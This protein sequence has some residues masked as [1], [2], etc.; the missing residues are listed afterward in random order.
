M[1]IDDRF[2]CAS[3]P[4]DWQSIDD[5]DA[6]I[7]HL[8]SLLPQSIALR[9]ESNNGNMSKTARQLGINRRTLT[10]MVE[11]GRHEHSYLIDGQLCTPMK[12]HADRIDWD[13]AQVA[14]L[15]RLA[16]SHSLTEAVMV[17][18]YTRGQLRNAADR[19][20]I[21]FLP[22]TREVPGVP[23]EDYPLVVAL[24]DGGMSVKAIAAKW[25]C[26]Q[27]PIYQILKQHKE[28]AK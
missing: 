2:I 15:R 3:S 12:T 25:E 21:K 23:K 11:E 4:T 5:K 8:L 10:T 22:G 18:D 9:I 6:V 19:Y 14:E 26:S 17:T 24:R 28:T 27:H 7:S 13:E 16:E 20:D 1:L